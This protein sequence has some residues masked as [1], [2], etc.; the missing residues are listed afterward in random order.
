MFVLGEREWETKDL[1]GKSRWIKKDLIIY[2]WKTKILLSHLIWVRQGIILSLH[3]YIAFRK[4]C[5]K[6]LEGIYSLVSD[7]AGDLRSGGILKLWRALSHPCGISKLYH[8]WPQDCQSAATGLQYPHN[9][10]YI[11]MVLWHL[12]RFFFLDLAY[13]FFLSY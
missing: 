11:G 7:K 13:T 10:V 9:I 5:Y 6:S 8:L 2:D 3:H 1:E 4:Q 12:Q